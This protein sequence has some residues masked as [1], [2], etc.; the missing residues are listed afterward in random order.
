[1][2]DYDLIYDADHRTAAF[3]EHENGTLVCLAGPGTGKTFSLLARSSALARRG[4]PASAVCYLTFIRVIADTFVDDYERRFGHADPL[5]VPRMTT[6]HSFA[7]RL[8]RNLGFQMGYDGELF[9]TNV[10]EA[11]D[12]GTTFQEDLL[13]IVS[14]EGCRTVSQLRGHLKLLQ[15]AWQNRDPEESLKEPVPSL[16]ADTYELLRSYRLCDF[17]Q[18]VNLASRLLRTADPPDWIASIK[19]YFVDEYQDF[20]KAEQEIIRQLAERA[21]SVTVV[22]DDDQSLYSSRGGSPTGMRALFSDISNGRVS[23]VKCYRCKETIVDRANTFQRTMGETARP[24]R[25]VATGGKVQC[26]RFKSSKAEVDYLVTYLSERLAEL[27]EAPEPK[28]RVVCLFPSRKIMFAYLAA[29]SPHVRCETR[30]TKPAAQ[31]RAVKRIFELVS[32]P[33]Q[34]F[35]QRL[36]LNKFSAIK[37]RNRDAI[38]RR[39]RERDTSPKD[40]VASLLAE[41]ALTAEAA[42]AAHAFCALISAAENGD[43][44]YLADRLATTVRLNPTA[45]RAHLELITGAQAGTAADLIEAALDDCLPETA[46]S[47]EDPKTVQ[48]LTIH[49]SKGLTRRVVVLPGMEEACIPGDAEGGAKEEKERLFFVALSRA[50]DHLLLTF[51]NRRGRGDPL[52]FQ[53]A[54][55]G[56][57]SS[58]LARAGLVAEFQEN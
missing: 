6:L 21:D 44:G 19:H 56:Q 15:S 47:E 37:P 16:I 7:C 12:A 57:A 10:T 42:A 38:V 29:L 50:T 27:P 46:A 45:L 36:V 51:P 2:T 11:D 58:F 33:T 26:L 52:N 17:E 48:F 30:A 54:G 25:S 43:L 55:R 14:R 5:S 35:A 8:V 53:M 22:G 23:L 34:R 4:V 31:R 32:R 28:Q 41:G 1:M 40:A 13:R 20:N 9:F 24:M 39:I 18:A 49:S 3:E